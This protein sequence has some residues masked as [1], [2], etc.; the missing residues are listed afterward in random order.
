MFY[1]DAVLG[2]KINCLGKECPVFVHILIYICMLGYGSVSA[3][4]LSNLETD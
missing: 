1:V 4:H 3:V 2:N